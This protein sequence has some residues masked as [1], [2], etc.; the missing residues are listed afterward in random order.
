LEEFSQNSFEIADCNIIA[1]SDTLMIVEEQV[2][3]NG[4]MTLVRVTR[5][6]AVK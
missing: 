4:A 5:V 2:M 1:L 6:P 3:I